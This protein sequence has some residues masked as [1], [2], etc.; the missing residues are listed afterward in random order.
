MA[1]NQLSHTQRMT[2]ICIAAEPVP[3]ADFDT[4]RIGIR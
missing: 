4:K 2:L 3:L 1:A